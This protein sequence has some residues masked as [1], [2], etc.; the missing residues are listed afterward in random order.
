ML[1]RRSSAPAAAAKVAVGCVVHIDWAIKGD[2]DTALELAALLKDKVATSKIF[3]QPKAAASEADE[4]AAA[5]MGS[6]DEGNPMEPRYYF[7]AKFTEAERAKATAEA[8]AK[9]KTQAARLAK[10]AGGDIGALRSVTARDASQT[11]SDLM[12]SYGY[13]NSYYVQRMLEQRGQAAQ[14]DEVFSDAPG[15]IS[16][17][18][19]VQAAFALKS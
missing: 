10:A 16:H 13:N 1:D 4:E 15:D 17:T 6:S 9:A 2:A 3:D 12:E 11:L 14:N 18:V 5:M 8:F 19:S 7:V